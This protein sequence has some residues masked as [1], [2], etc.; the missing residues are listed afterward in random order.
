MPPAPPISTPMQYKNGDT[1]SPF[2]L[3]FGDTSVGVMSN[4][5]EHIHFA[6]LLHIMDT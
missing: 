4:M 3:K 5:T 1:G 6:C 2:S